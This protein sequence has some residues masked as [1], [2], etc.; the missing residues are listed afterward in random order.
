MGKRPFMLLTFAIAALMVVAGFGLRVGA[1]DTATPGAAD[2]VTRPTHIHAGSCPEV[3]DVVYPLNELTAA[4]GPD[5]LAEGGTPT[6]AAVESPAA[7]TPVG[8][9]EVIAADERAAAS[10]AA[11]DVEVVAESTTIIEASLDDI[12]GA[13]HAINVHES[14]ENIQNYIACGDL[15]GPATDGELHIELQELNDSGFVGRAH[16]TENG[17][18][19]TTVTVTLLLSGTTA[20]TPAA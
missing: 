5:Y 18:G 9:G 12:L 8:I 3:G 13:E 20:A 4:L 10:P 6:V 17:D 19:T 16:L 7:S 14:P 2:A 15:T 1:Q 11:A